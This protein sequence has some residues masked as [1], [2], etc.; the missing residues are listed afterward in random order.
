MRAVQSP[1]ARDRTITALCDQF[2][3]ASLPDLPKMFDDM[4]TYIPT[5]TRRFITVVYPVMTDLL[6][7]PEKCRA[8][9]DKAIDFLSLILE[10]AEL[11]NPET[12][13]YG[14]IFSSPDF[15]RA[16]FRHT[17]LNARG[18]F[19][20][21]VLEIIQ[22]Y[23]LVKEPTKIVT[24]LLESKESI[25]PLLHGCAKQNDYRA[26][27]LCNQLVVC[28]PDV[29]SLLIAD[30]K[31]LLLKFP[32]HLLVDLFIASA[33]LK[34]TMSDEEFEAWLSR[35]REFSLSDVQQVCRFFPAIWDK[36]FSLQ[37]L[38]NATP[39]EKLTFVNWI[40]TMG[41]QDFVLSP[42]MTASAIDSI[43]APPDTLAEDGLAAETREVDTRVTH[44]FPRLYVL[45]FADPNNVTPQ[46]IE[47]I[48]GFTVSED[49]YIA[50][51]ALQVLAIWIAKFAFVPEKWPVYQIATHVDAASS[52]GLGHLYRVVMHYLARAL[53]LAEGIVR[54]DPGVRFD[55]KDTVKVTR[56]PWEF[57]HFTGF[58]KTVPLFDD[59]DQA[60]ALNVLGELMDYF[61][62][63]AA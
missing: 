63:E 57:P 8:A 43:L 37:M 51:G 18:R 30:I 29:K 58:V 10:S 56:E 47:L 2:R 36:P 5:Y 4:A 42:E 28:H 17:G 54:A 39:A 12:D 19:D 50:A 45:S 59:W 61:S 55:P 26:C 7:E 38:L 44:V 11:R 9:T 20:R 33:E 60:K 1:R 48:Y 23:L 25:F 35:Q 41:P 32:P 49:T 62:I 31:P 15:L 16:L 24:L 14:V 21:R 22:T 6:R 34:E 53:P 27:V 52:V 40:H 46:G 13:P 3:R